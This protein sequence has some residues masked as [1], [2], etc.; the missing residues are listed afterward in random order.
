MLDS[1]TLLWIAVV[2]LLIAVAVLA[3]RLWQM[4]TAAQTGNERPEATADVDASPSRASTR[5]TRRSATPPPASAGGTAANPA[6]ERRTLPP[7][8]RAGQEPR[9]SAGESFRLPRPRT[10][11]PPPALAGNV[12]GNS[13]SST[14]SSHARKP[15]GSRPPAAPAGGSGPTDENDP[16]PARR[17]AAATGGQYPSTGRSPADDPRG[18]GTPAS[19]LAQVKSWAYQLQGIELAPTES[20]PFEL[21]VI[22]YS[23][24]GS[25]EEA[26]TRREISR[27]KRGN[28][29]GQRLVYAY[30]SV[31]EAESYRYYWQRSWKR[32]PPD[33]LIGE[34]KEWRENYYV[35]FWSPDWQRIVFGGEES[36]ISRIARAGFDGIYLDRCDV[37]EEI[38]E[39]HP[40]VAGERPDIEGDM[41]RF[42]T[43][44][45]SWVR[46]AH[47]GLG[48]M[49]QN[50]EG[51]LAHAPV[52]AAL[53]AV[54]KEELLFGV[55]TA[56][57]R[58][59]QE[60]VRQSRT[61]LDQMRRDGKAVFVVEYLDKPELRLEAAG[62]LRAIGYVPYM[63]RKDRELATLEADQ[64]RPAIA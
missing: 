61:A 33:W 7:A 63:A 45:S 52:R 55:D 19:A 31:G 57:K 10:S 21:L 32:S 42:V 36:Y 18:N 54:A 48:V 22:D 1:N 47:P 44:L 46:G 58:N 39:H 56:E 37:Y 49:M 9:S 38:A 30:L 2:V 53:D 25:E 14:S 16:E 50:A 8:A 41:V 13:P 28:G 17:G 15:G 40:G 29:G 4:S 62:A 24:D 3:W 6:D 64:P 34:N 60:D 27:L 59:D 20:T 43:A 5:S 26:F 23:R 11:R 35:R 51:L 12:P